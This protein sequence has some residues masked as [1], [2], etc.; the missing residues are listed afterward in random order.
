M[1]GRARLAPA[2]LAF[3]LGCSSPSAPAP[4]GGSWHVVLSGLEGTLLSAWGTS[5]A[6]VFAVG[7]SLG[8]GG[9]AIALHYDGSA[10]TDLA[11]GGA[12]TLWWAHGTG[13]HDVW[14]VGEHG[15]IEH[16]DGTHFVQHASGTT[17]TLFGVWAAAP[18]DVWAVGGT[19][20]G[21]DPND[22]VLHYDGAVWTPAPPPMAL[23]VAYFKVWGSGAEDVFVVGQAGTIWHR[24]GGA[25]TLASNPPLAMGTLFTVNGCGPAEVYAVG[26][27]DVLRFDGSAWA[28][29][30]V[31]ATLTNDV[32]GVACAAPS[33]LEAAW[34]GR[35]VEPADTRKG[36]NRDHDHENAHSVPAAAEEASPPGPQD[37]GQGADEPGANVVTTTSPTLPRREPRELMWREARTFSMR[38][39]R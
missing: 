31:S 12:D 1:R 36:G 33:A 37:E 18:N 11:P 39:P 28:R 3:A 35:G 34:G 13:P 10:W 19:P 14:M 25:W 9:P 16:W 22:V 21:A 38:K 2:L 15:R 8:N 24:K 7:G 27:R 23:G 5:P 20:G 30:D 26:G 32:N 6:D 29:L 17:A 4:A